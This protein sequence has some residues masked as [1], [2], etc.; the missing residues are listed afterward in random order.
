MQKKAQICEKTALFCFVDPKAAPPPSSANASDL[1][2]S[3]GTIIY[4]FS[5]QRFC[6]FLIYANLFASF[7]GIYGFCNASKISERSGSDLAKWTGPLTN[8]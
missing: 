7:C 1:T 6:F 4:R 8:Y 5:L 3:K 2:A